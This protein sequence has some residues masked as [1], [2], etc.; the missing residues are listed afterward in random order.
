MANLLSWLLNQVRKWNE[1]IWHTPISEL[2]KGKTFLVKQV[3]IIHLSAKGFA[4]DKVQLRA[5]ALTFYSLLSL[6]PVL[7]IALPLPKGSGSVR[8]LKK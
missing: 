5:S 6:I 7:A 4:K 8:I 2:S 1:F 3:R